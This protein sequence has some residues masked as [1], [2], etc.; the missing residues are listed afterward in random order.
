MTIAS[1]R[2]AFPYQNDVLALPVSNAQEASTWYGQNFGMQEVER[3]AQPKPFV[4][5]ERDGVKIGFAENGGDPT[6][7]G[8][9]VLV[10][11]IT[12]LRTELES[13]GVNFSDWRE[14]ERDGK[15]LKSFFCHC[16]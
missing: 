4:I 12:E 1:F 6:Q 7:D 10:A 3:G 5:L 8:A 15:K 2:A 14:D 11:G 9:A 13:R 16:A